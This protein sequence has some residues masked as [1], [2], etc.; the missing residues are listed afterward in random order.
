MIAD[1]IVY[2]ENL[3]NLFRLFQKIDAAGDTLLRVFSHE[4]L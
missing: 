1:F 2:I 4:S 3:I